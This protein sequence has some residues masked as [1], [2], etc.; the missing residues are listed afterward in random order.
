MGWHTDR[1]VERRNKT[2]FVNLL[3]VKEVKLMIVTLYSCCILVYL[4]KELREHVKEEKKIPLFI[5]KFKFLLFKVPFYELIQLHVLYTL[6]LTSTFAG[7]FP[8]MPK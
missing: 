2:F 4:R 7:M 6:P 5:I 1:L 8:K 3:F